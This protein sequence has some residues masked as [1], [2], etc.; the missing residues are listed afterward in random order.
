MAKLC[1]WRNSRSKFRCSCALSIH[2]VY[3][4]SQKIRE[5]RHKLKLLSAH[6]CGAAS[7][8]L[9][10]KVLQSW[11]IPEIHHIGSE[12]RSFHSLH[13][14][15]TYFFDKSNQ[16][17]AVAHISSSYLPNSQ[18]NNKQNASTTSILSLCKENV[19]KTERVIKELV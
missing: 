4:I 5:D 12:D 7:R 17:H 11:V 10:T 1:L 2:E 16:S 9:C 6:E 8:Q 14:Q 13:F 18:K 15:N 19:N 3:K